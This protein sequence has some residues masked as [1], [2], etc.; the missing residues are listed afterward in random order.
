MKDKGY[1]EEIVKRL[2]EE[3]KAR[4]ISEVMAEGIDPAVLEKAGFEKSSDFWT[5]TIRLK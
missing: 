4:S 3:T 1:Q 5:K 2:I